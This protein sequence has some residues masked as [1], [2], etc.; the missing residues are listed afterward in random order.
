VNQEKV[1]HLTGIQL[2]LQEQDGN[3]FTVI[4]NHN[5]DL[6]P[7]IVDECI[8]FFTDR[9]LLPKALDLS[10]IDAAQYVYDEQIFTVYYALAIQMLM[11]SDRDETAIILN[12]LNTFDD[13]LIGLKIAIPPEFESEIYSIAKYLTFDKSLSDYF[14]GSA[15]ARAKVVKS[16]Q[17]CLGAILSKAKILQK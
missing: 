6:F 13:F 11:N 8:L 15:E 17:W 14:Q 4:I 5:G 1:L 9:S 16:A 7:L 12:M 3:L 2:D 10:G